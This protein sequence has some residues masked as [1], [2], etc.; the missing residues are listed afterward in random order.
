[1]KRRYEP[2][3][4][5]YDSD[6]HLGR[7]G[8]RTWY[9]QGPSRLDNRDREGRYNRQGQKGLRACVIAAFLPEESKEPNGDRKEWLEEEDRLAWLSLQ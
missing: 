4:L 3:S 8:E 2:P 5:N 7:G 1:M 6:S 9:Q